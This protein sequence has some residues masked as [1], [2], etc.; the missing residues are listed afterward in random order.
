MCQGTR[1]QGK[2]S[3][4]AEDNILATSWTKKCEE[5]DRAK[6]DLS[7]FHDGSGRKVPY[8]FE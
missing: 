5:I 2:V 8:L 6:L 3:W 7:A 4:C 1:L